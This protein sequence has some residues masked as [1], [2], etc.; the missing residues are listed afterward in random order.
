MATQAVEALRRTANAAFWQGFMQAPDV[1]QGLVRQVSS[2]SDQETYP[3][4]AYAPPVREMKGGRVAK[5]VPEISYTLKNKKWENTVPIEYETWRFG[6]LGVVAQLT[7]GLGRKAREYPSKL[8]ATVLEDGITELC[9]DGQFF[10]DTDHVD[11]GAEFSTNQDNDLAS[12]AAAAAINPDIIEFKTV[13]S[14][15]VNKLYT[16]KDG[17][18]DPANVP[19]PGQSFVLLIP[20]EYEEVAHELSTSSEISDGTTQ[21]SNPL[22][23]RLDVRIVPWWAVPVSGSTA[24]FM[25]ANAMNPNKPLVVQTAD[26]IR[27]EDNLGGDL[28]FDTKERHFGS[29]GYYNIGYGDWRPIVRMTLTDT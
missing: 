23:G 1:F 16:F 11:P 29:F 21:L 5:P 19:V 18:G 28:E 8:S 26:P 4:F 27:V 7:Q 24:M 14:L 6:K 22:A 2:D 20:V 25:V 17:A 12:S 13:V 10:F 3:A 9:Y 15:C